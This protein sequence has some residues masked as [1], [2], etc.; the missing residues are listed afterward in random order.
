MFLA[1]FF[2]SRP[3]FAANHG[4]YF[5]APFCNTLVVEV[6]VQERTFERMVERFFF[7]ETVELMLWV[8]VLLPHPQFHDVSLVLVS[9]AVVHVLTCRK[10]F[11][12]IFATKFFRTHFEQ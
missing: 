4:A 10:S 7:F 8:Q 11:S 1:H 5:D 12:P 9:H 3:N 2:K 6:L